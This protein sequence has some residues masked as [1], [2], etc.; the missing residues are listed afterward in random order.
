MNVF[1][2]HPLDEGGWWI[3]A[4]GHLHTEQRIV[5]QKEFEALCEIAYAVDAYWQ[6]LSEQ[7]TDQAEI[8]PSIAY[9]LHIIDTKR[10]YELPVAGRT[11]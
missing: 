1:H 8:P 11:A 10:I 9:A 6:I 4:M 2:Y 3:S 7:E 5:S